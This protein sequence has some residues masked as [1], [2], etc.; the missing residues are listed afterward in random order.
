MKPHTRRAIAYI[1]ASI[2]SRKRATTVFDYATSQYYNFSISLSHSGVAAYDYTQN[3]HISGSYTSIFHYG[4]NHYISLKI[5]GNKFSGF[6]YGESC[7][8]S[9]S[10]NGKSVSMFD[11]GVSS[12]FNFSI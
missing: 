2:I 9:G 4:E 7:H 6:D 8:F 12:Y 11:Y 5:D 3:C 1:A 10:V